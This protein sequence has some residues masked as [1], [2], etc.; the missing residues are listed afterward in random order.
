MHD[1]QIWIKTKDNTIIV[2]KMSVDGEKINIE[3]YFSNGMEL[4]I[5][6]VRG[7]G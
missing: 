3:E 7:E 1:D 4:G 6:R 5:Q 2:S